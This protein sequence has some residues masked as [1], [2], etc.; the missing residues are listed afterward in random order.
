VRA[1]L[2]ADDPQVREETPVDVNGAKG[3]CHGRSGEVVSSVVW[4]V[5][6]HTVIALDQLRMD[7]SEQT[8]LRIARSV[9]PDPAAMRLPLK[10]E[11]LPGGMSLDFATFG[12][13]SGT[14]W[15]AQLHATAAGGSLT[16]SARKPDK[17]ELLSIS[18]MLSPTTTAPVGGTPLTVGTHP[19]RLVTRTDVQ[20]MN[21]RYLVVDIGGGKLLTVIGQRPTPDSV[22]VDDLIRI[23]QHAALDPAPDVSWIGR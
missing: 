17:Q 4:R 15:Y 10:L 2:G 18:V 8:M 1:A 5:D 20:G 9:R 23:A 16:S 7:L 13:D 12:G 3:F 14:A 21:M 6:A 11:W 19:A 22:S